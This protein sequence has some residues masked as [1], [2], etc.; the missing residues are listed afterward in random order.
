MGVLFVKV[1]EAN[2]MDHIPYLLEKQNELLEQ[3]NQI[4]LQLIETLKWLK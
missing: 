2:N 3:Q 4:L 1:K